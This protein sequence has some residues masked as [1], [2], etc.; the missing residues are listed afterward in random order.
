MDN[1]YD[2]Y[3]DDLPG[4]KNIT[5]KFFAQLDE[6]QQNALHWA[7]QGDWE[8]LHRRTHQLKS[9]ATLFELSQLTETLGNL[10]NDTRTA[11]EQPVPEKIKEHCKRFADLVAEARNFVAQ[12]T[13]DVFK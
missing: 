13:P 12:K 3:R 1:I 5:G 11:S 7:E 4:L 8:I 10:A 6:L 2:L 9:T